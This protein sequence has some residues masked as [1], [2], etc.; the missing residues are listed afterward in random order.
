MRHRRR[1]SPD[2]RADAPRR[3]CR[4]CGLCDDFRRVVHHLWPDALLGSP[5]RA[6]QPVGGDQRP[7]TSVPVET[8]RCHGASRRPGDCPTPDGP[9][10]SPRPLCSS[11]PRL[12]S[13][14][15]FPLPRLDLV[16]P[17]SA[18]SSTARLPTRAS[19]ARTPVSRRPPS[20]VSRSAPR[21][22]IPLPTPLD[23]SAGAHR[24]PPPMP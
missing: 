20:T 4:L 23:P 18:F 5:R 7:A 22:S 24:Q 10:A 15:H 8:A 19:T 2:A 21:H 16:T 13:P 1:D 9:L 14:F 3:R 12:A 17:R 11:A 6:R